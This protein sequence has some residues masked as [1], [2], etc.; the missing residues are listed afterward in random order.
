MEVKENI[1]VLNTVEVESSNVIINHRGLK[2]SLKDVLDRL[3]HAEGN[4][5]Y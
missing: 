4:G 5:R 3:E 1:K 2:T